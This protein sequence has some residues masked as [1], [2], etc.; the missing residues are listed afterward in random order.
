MHKQ[1]KTWADRQKDF[2]FFTP[3]LLYWNLDVDRDLVE[4]FIA[5]TP[6]PVSLRPKKCISDFD[7]FSITPAESIIHT[8]RGDMNYNIART[9]YICPLE[10]W[11]TLH[12]F[13]SEVGFIDRR[14]N[15]FSRSMPQPDLVIPDFGAIKNGMTQTDDIHVAA[16]GIY[17]NKF[18]S[19]WR[20]DFS[21]NVYNPPKAAFLSA[22]EIAIT[23][24]VM[25]YKEH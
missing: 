4:D 19:I 21:P 23:D 18:C 12:S 15:L 11:P 25:F 8:P 24:G 7:L 6:L 20:Q 9:I 16:Y 10:S 14:T 17:T 2:K 22:S 1:C 3:G 5:D 13:F